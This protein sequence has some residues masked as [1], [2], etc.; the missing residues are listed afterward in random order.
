MALEEE[1]KAAYAEIRVLREQVQYLVSFMMG[2]ERECLEK[3]A[4]RCVGRMW[5]G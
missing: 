4:R 5:R 3:L 2:M 1:L